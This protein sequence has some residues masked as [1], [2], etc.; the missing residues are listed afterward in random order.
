MEC[1]KIIAL[2]FAVRIT[3]ATIAEFIVTPTNYLDNYLENVK[4]SLRMKVA[5]Y[6][7]HVY[8]QENMIFLV[9]SEHQMRQK[10][11]LMEMKLSCGQMVI[12]LTI[13]RHN[14]IL[15]FLST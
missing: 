6:R 14:I 9:L 4:V 13:R 3:L 2:P 1:I 11:L 7:M 12:S 5:C 8:Y 10:F 15:N